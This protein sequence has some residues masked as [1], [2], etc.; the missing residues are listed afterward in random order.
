MRSALEWLSLC[1][2]GRRYLPLYSA[3][4]AAGALF[5]P[6]PLGAAAA[7]ALSVAALI[8]YACCYLRLTAK[9]V[10]DSKAK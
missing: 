7:L 3:A 6:R 10:G 8:R 1:R 4:M 9:N 5:L 2:L